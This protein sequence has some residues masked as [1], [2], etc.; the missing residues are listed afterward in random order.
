MRSMLRRVSATVGLCFREKGLCGAETAA[1]KRPVTF[2]LSSAET[3]PRKK[4]HQFGAICTTPGNLCLYGTA[5]WGWEDSNFQPNHYQSVTL[6][7]RHRWP[8]PAWRGRRSA[9]RLAGG[10]VPTAPDA[11]PS[12]AVIARILEQSLWVVAFVRGNGIFAAAEIISIE[13]QLAICGEKGSHQA[14]P[15]LRALR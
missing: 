6:S 11:R 15:L 9:H 1:S 3:K 2:N 5:W 10:M 13:I 4:T 12:C 8:A 14:T 7:S